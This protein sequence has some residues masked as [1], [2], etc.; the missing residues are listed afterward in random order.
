M[1]ASTIPRYSRPGKQNGYPTTSLSR[2]DDIRKFEEVGTHPAANH[3]AIADAL[4]FLHQIGLERKS[5]R[6]RF[7]RDRWAR[8]LAGKPNVTLYTS[9]D[10]E[11]S[12]ALATVAIAGVTPN[13]LVGHLWQ[14]HRLIVT[15]ME[16]GG[17][18]SGIRV[19]PN[20]YTSLAEVDLFAEVME[21]IAEKGLP[22]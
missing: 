13:Q 14:K 15:G 19:T 16:Y 17:N 6:L 20:V 3:N 18:V 21:T 11:H 22:A 2:K 12:C 10:P 7:L 1:T 8:R 4:D 9:L 5:A